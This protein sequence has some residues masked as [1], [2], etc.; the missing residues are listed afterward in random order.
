MSI[1][2]ARNAIDALEAQ[3]NT[4]IARTQ[5]QIPQPKAF[6]KYP[7][8]STYK[9]QI[10][11]KD[12]CLNYR[13]EVWFENTR[14]TVEDINNR[15]AL[16]KSLFDKYLEDCV[17]ITQQNSLIAIHNKT[18]HEKIKDI[19][20]WIGVGDSF[21]TYDYA[22][23]RSRTKTAQ[24]HNA[25]YLSD[26]ARVA[27][28]YAPQV[29]TTY[30]WKH[31]ED[32]ANKLISEI[33]KKEREAKALVAAKEK[34]KEMMRLAIKY[35]VEDIE[36]EWL[37]KRAILNKDK[38]LRLAHFLNMN[39]NDWSD[40][41]AYA[42]TGIDGFEVVTG[43]DVLIEECIRGIIDSDDCCDGRAFR[44]C[45]WNYGRLFGMVSDD[46]LLADYHKIIELTG[47]DY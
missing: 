31:Y 41:Y 32:Y 7:D 5:E 22:T 25:G 11:W 27:P 8:I 13:I 20:K 33:Q 29:K 3:M 24:K 39:R 9:T 40:G 30:E 14:N 6:L 36:D 34:Q 19:M 17:E 16:I 47:G 10:G 18:V 1:Q 15:L 28:T 43:D 45:E 42:E 21:S 4:L 26:L 2:Q 23:S 37:L 38:Y 44:D 46:Q 35:A 12:Y